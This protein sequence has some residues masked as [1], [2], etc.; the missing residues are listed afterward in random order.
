MGQRPSAQHQ[1]DRR[2]NH[3]GYSKSNCHWVLPTANGR[4]KRT[5]VTVN[6][7]G[8]KT[9]LVEASELSGVPYSALKH[10]LRAG[11]T[12][13][14]GLFAKTNLKTGRAL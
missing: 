11:R 14:T 1:L 12:T 8:R 13:K 3:L 5:N 4:N 2:K 10:R 6:Y 7:Q 9:T